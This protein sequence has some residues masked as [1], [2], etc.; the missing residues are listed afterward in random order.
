[1]AMTNAYDVHHA[2]FLHQFVA[3]EQ[4]KRQKPTSLTAKEHAKNRSQ[5]R[6]VKLVKPNYAFETKVNISGICKK[7]TH[8][9]TEMELGDS[10]TTLKNVTRNITMYFVHFVCERYSIESSGTSAEYIRQFQMLYT[11][12]TGQYMDRNDSKQVYNL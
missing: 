3:K 7:W 6:S 1:M 5:L 9:C 10:K 11:T 8:Y 2:D 12:V 4:K